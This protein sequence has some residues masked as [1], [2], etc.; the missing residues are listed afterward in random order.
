[1]QMSAV[2]QS[3]HRNGLLKRKVPRAEST[4]TL[5]LPF[6]PDATWLAKDIPLA[7][8]GGF[9]RMKHSNGT[10]PSPPSIAD[11]GIRLAPT[12]MRPRYLRIYN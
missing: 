4:N 2:G 11:A 3:W 5:R 1:M 12:E 9:G 8:N 7:P 6:L 10:V